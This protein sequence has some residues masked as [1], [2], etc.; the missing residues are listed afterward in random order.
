[1]GRFVEGFERA[2]A[3][4]EAREAEARRR[5]ERVA[6]ALKNLSDKL[7]ED[8]DA[9]ERQQITMRIEHGSLVLKRM[10]QPMASVSFD[11]DSRRFKVHE[12]SVSEGKTEMHAQD[13]EDCALKLGEYVYSLKGGSA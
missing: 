1:M 11:P 12:Y 6:A 2:K 5:A 10:Q 7:D 4:D 13:A 3:A 9:L 8:R